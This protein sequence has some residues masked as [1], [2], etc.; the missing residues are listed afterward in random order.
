MQRIS[1]V[2]EKIESINISSGGIE[3]FNLFKDFIG[4]LDSKT[5]ESE[6]IVKKLEDINKIIKSTTDLDQLLSDA[7]GG[8]GKKEINLQANL[9]KFAQKAGVEAVFTQQTK[10]MSTSRANVT[11]NFEIKMSADD[12]ERGIVQR[13]TSTIRHFLIN[14]TATETTLPKDFNVKPNLGPEAKPSAGEGKK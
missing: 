8:G 11:V 4:G 6:V 9:E 13:S 5:F 1:K 2:L 3:K 14:R 10:T 7:V 12:L